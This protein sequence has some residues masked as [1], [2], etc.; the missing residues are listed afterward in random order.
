MADRRATTRVHALAL[1]AGSSSVRAALYDEQGTPVPDTLCQVDTD[2][3]MRHGGVAVI[4]AEAMR[5]ALEQAIDGTLSSGAAQGLE[6]AVVGMTTFWH[7][8]VALD[9]QGR[10]LTP[11][12]SWAD[13]RSEP[14]A[15]VL[16]ER[17]DDDAIHQR[18][19]CILHPSY[20]PAKLHWLRRDEPELFARSATFVSFAQ[21]CTGI[22]LGTLAS[23]VSMASGSGIFNGKTCEWDAE[24]S[25]L[26][27]VRPDQL[28]EILTDPE[29]LPPVQPAYASRWPALKHVPWRAPI[30]DGVASNIGAGCIGADRLA[31]MVGTS[32]ALRR[33][34]PARLDERIPP[35][36][37]RYRLDRAYTVP[38]GALS[39]GGS[40]YAWLQETLRLPSG[41]ECEAELAR[42]EPGQHG[43]VVLPFF[44][45]ERSLGWVGDATAMISGLKQ[46]TTPLDIFHAAIEAVTYRFAAL[47]NA[48]SRGDETIVTTGGGLRNSPAWLQM[49]ADAFG[50]PIVSS[51]VEESSAR[52]AALVALRDAGIV[53]RTHLRNAPLSQVYEPRPAF[54][55]RH[56]DGLW[57]QQSFYDRE[58]G[59]QGVNLLARQTR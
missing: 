15:N 58:V 19:G 29:L 31:L 30:G 3:T 46:H 9:G 4:D 50:R 24:L 57:R 33:C 34:E 44:V 2:L 10:P 54:H 42:R 13:T 51:A 5:L 25:E 43:L 12:L 39:N 41:A 21:Y 27:G 8:L 37:W 28:G 38:G 53:N 48:L 1:D 49:L 32:G 6:I 23:S 11:V 16:R 17:L 36:L 26:L 45:G 7:S 22:W 55:E 40:V 56:L 47:V 35:G 59:Q 14:D 18:T 20:L 52:G